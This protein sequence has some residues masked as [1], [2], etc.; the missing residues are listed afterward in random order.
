[1]AALAVP[2][3]LVEEAAVGTN[4]L[5]VVAD[6]DG[7]EVGYCGPAAGYTGAEVRS[8]TEDIRHA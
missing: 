3:D 4:A 7:L 2:K 5:A 8:H 6:D 1:M